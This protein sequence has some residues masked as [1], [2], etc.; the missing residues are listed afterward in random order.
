MNLD[1]ALH[2]VYAAARMAPL[3][4]DQHEMITKCMQLLTQAIKSVDQPKKE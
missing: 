3:T 4:A 1:Q 2:N